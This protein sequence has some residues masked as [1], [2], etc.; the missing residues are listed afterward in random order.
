MKLSYITRKIL[1]RI[2][3]LF[4]IVIVGYFYIYYPFYKLFP[5]VWW[6]WW[7]WIVGA[8][9]LVNI[10]GLICVQLKKWTKGKYAEWDVEDVSHKLPESFIT[11]T[12]IVPGGIGN[13]DEVIVG[14]TGIWVIEVKSHAGKITFDGRELRRNGELFKKDFLKQVWNQVNAVRDILKRDLNKDFFIHP[15]ICFSDRDAKLRLGLRPVK[16]VYIIGRKWLK[17]LILENST[18]LS[19]STIGEIVKTLEKYKV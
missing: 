15:V 14:P 9:I 12:D 8:V 16:G 7:L 4:V 17:R 19:D 1:E 6:L 13:V 11:I 10:F 2:G 18:K 3:W 5:D